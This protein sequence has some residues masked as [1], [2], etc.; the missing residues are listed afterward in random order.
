MHSQRDSGKL[1]FAD[2]LLMVW[3]STPKWSLGAGFLGELPLFFLK[4][5]HRVSLRGAARSKH[6]ALC[7]LSVPLSLYRIAD[8]H[9]RSDYFLMMR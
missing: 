3:Q 9:N 1:F 6:G 4:K 8:R 7:S 5:G 2:T